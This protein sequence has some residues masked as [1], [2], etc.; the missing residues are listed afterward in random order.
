MDARDFF[1]ESAKAARILK[2]R[3]VMLYGIFNEPPKD[4]DETIVGFDYAPYS[5]I[6][7]KASCVVHQGGVGTTSEVLR[8]GRPHLIMPYSHDQPD[9]AARC[10]RLGVARTIS[11]DNYTG[12]AAAKELREILSDHLFQSR[13]DEVKKTVVAE[14]GTQTACDAIEDIMKVKKIKNFS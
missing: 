3:A 9:N 2:K 6:F 13:A 5:L 14:Y 7:P 11:R 8:A 12:D 1:E 4:L 10:G